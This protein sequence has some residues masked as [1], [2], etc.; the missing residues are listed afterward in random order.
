MEEKRSYDLFECGKSYKF[1]DSLKILS[2]AN[3]YMCI[4]VAVCA[5]VFVCISDGFGLN[6]KSS[7][8]VTIGETAERFLVIFS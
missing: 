3:F 4:W 7:L 2:W 8:N 6:K 5:C 1:I